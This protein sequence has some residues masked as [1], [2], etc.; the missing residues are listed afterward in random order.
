MNLWLTRSK[1]QVKNSNNQIDKQIIRK[2]YI[3]CVSHWMG[4]IH[5]TLV[6]SAPQ[7]NSKFEI[8]IQA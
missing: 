8:F 4:K 3:S 2:V 7:G 6:P 1:Y 5:S